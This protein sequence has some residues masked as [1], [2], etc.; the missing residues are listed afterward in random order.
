MS[1]HA[2]IYAALRGQR[3]VIVGGDSRPAALSRLVTTLELAALVHCQT[4][5]SDASPRRFATEIHRPGV[6]LVIWLR[7]LSRTD[8]GECLHKLCRRLCIPW[9]DSFHIPHPNTLVALIEKHRLLDALLKRRAQVE[10]AMACSA[11]QIGG[12]A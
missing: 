3:V 8:H 11:R 10:R 2:P 4:R 1:A 9:V 6:V 12:A 7:G 5:R